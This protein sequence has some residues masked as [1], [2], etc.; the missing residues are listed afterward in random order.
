[1]SERLHPDAAADAGPSASRT[2]G[3]ARDG[4]A[5]L[6]ARTPHPGSREEGAPG[7]GSPDQHAGS[8]DG[9]GRFDTARSPGRFLPGGETS[10]EVANRPSA[11]DGRAIASSRPPHVA[12]NATV[13]TATLSA[14]DVKTGSSRGHTSRDH[15]SS[16]IRSRSGEQV[17]RHGYRPYPPHREASRIP[18]RADE[19]E[20]LQAR[21]AVDENFR[22]RRREPEREQTRLRPALAREQGRA[23]RDAATAAEAS[24]GAEVEARRLQ[25]EA[26][27]AQ[28]TMPAEA[29]E[30]RRQQTADT[31]TDQESPLVS[32]ASCT[33]ASVDLA[34]TQ[35][36]SAMES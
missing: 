18:T 8:G 7:H 9:H 32:R 14:S 16:P 5:G 21:L 15:S 34:P 20:S 2:R 4:R 6:D 33:P 19:P 28:G 1:M 17:S 24:G 29:A 11:S 31:A 10:S 23:R 36:G 3:P 35:A 25:A 12:F 30:L 26:E 22:F 27:R 13:S